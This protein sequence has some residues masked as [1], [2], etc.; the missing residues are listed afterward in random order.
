MT[1]EHDEF[2]RRWAA[3]DDREKRSH[4]RPQRLRD[5]AT[6]L[7]AEASALLAKTGDKAALRYG[8]KVLRKAAKALRSDARDA[9]H[10][11]GCLVQLLGRGDRCTC[12]AE[13]LHLGQRR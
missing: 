12:G 11:P 7:D 3:D 2:F 9:M 10:A 6:M 4:L 13:P 5:V 1:I 8:A